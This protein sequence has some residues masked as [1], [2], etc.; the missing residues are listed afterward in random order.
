MKVVKIKKGV[1]GKTALFTLL[2]IAGTF[3]ETTIFNCL[4]NI[5]SEG[6]YESN[7]PRESFVTFVNISGLQ[8]MIFFVQSSFPHRVR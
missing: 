5:P 1:T 4:C 6:Q 2:L 3:V 8:I 7:Y